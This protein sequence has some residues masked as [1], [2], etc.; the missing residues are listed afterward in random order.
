[1]KRI[2]LLS[3]AASSS[4]RLWIK[5]PVICATVIAGLLL[6][7]WMP[8]MPSFIGQESWPYATNEAVAQHLIFGRDFVFSIGPLGSAFTHF[9]SHRCTR[10]VRKFS[11]CVR[12]VPASLCYGRDEKYAY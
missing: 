11:D 10:A 12:P 4:S 8:S 9:S 2:P 5:I 7:P 3:G 1:M 6:V